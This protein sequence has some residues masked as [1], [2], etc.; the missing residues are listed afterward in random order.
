MVKDYIYYNGD[1]N[2]KSINGCVFSFLDVKSISS[3]DD[4]RNLDF[5]FLNELIYYRLRTFNVGDLVWG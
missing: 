3:E 2:V 5:F 1:F 4:L